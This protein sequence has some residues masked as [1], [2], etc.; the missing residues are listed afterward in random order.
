M[1]VEE[2]IAALKEMNAHAVLGGKGTPDVCIQIR[3]LVNGFFSGEKP[4]T[5]LLE[6]ADYRAKVPTE[7]WSA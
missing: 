4:R 7:N 2:F 3:G 6:A 1:S 5:V